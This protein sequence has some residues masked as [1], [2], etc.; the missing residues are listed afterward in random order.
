M[1]LEV[2]SDIGPFAI[3]PDWLIRAEISDRAVRVYALLARH[4]DRETLAAWPKRSTMATALQCSS[5][6]IDRALRELVDL[7]AIS[8][9]HRFDT[10]GDPT[11]NLYHMRVTAADTV[12]AALRPPSRTTAATGDRD[13][14]A[15][16]AAPLRH[17]TITSGTTTIGRNDRRALIE[18]FESR[19][20]PKYPRKVA[21]RAAVAA[22]VKVSPDAALLERMIAALDRQRPDA[23]QLR[24][25]PHAST[26]LNG[27]R[28]L[29]EPIGSP[30]RAPG[31]TGSEA[32]KYS[33][34]EGAAQK[35]LERA[36]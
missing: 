33:T 16:V 26:W 32:G 34:I 3:V 13:G 18:Q 23:P 9:E 17:R 1:S 31:R 25:F 28:W 12:A 15:T 21:K 35:L 22:F 24:Y 19:F 6:S 5:D 27:E 2:K 11:S 7:K 8:I 4:A 10:A 29:D 14:A 20:W 30:N 36:S